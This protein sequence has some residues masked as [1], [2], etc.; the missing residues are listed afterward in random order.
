MA[1]TATTVAKKPQEEVQEGALFSLD[2]VRRM[3]KINIRL[4]LNQNAEEA[5]DQMEYVEVNGQ[6]TQIKRG[7]VVPVNWVVFEALINS[8]R[9][10]TSIVV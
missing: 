9:Y 7:E 4:P 2:E 10:D 8:G 6:I 5:Y 1:T 3:A